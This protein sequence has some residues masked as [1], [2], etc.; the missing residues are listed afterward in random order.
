MASLQAKSGS[1]RSSTAD[2]DIEI[3]RAVW[4]SCMREAGFGVS[5][6]SPRD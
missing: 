6:N 4:V 5:A 2:R 3:R 1:G